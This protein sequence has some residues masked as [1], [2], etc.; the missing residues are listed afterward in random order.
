MG[1]AKLPTATPLKT[2]K[3]RTVSLGKEGEVEE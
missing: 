3:R 1:V 2:D